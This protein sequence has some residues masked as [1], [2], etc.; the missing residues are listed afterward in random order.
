MSDNENPGCNFFKGLIFGAVLGAGLYYYLTVTEEG[1]KVQKKLKEKSQDVVDNLTDLV[2]EVEE[3]GEEFK[4]KAN[5][6]QLELEEKAEGVK[7]EVSKEAK[8]G[9]STI[10][11]LRERGRRAAKAFT[12]NGK[13][14]V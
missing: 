5:K 6:I 7:T 9:L 1:K 14:L 11:E 8:K 2:E 4:K 3:R 12:R 13:P 10:E